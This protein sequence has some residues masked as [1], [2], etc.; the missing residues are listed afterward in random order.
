MTGF[1][2][3]TMYY[4]IEIHMFDT[5]LERDS[6]EGYYAEEQCSKKIFYSNYMYMY[7]YNPTANS[8]SSGS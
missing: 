8:N 7:D 2:F 1:F 4:T 5:L 3:I 6:E